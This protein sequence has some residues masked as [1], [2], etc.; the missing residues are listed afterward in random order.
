MSLILVATITAAVAASAG[1]LAARRRRPEPSPRGGSD[2]PE[3]PPPPDPFA[4]LPLRLGDVVQSGH[5]ERWLAGAVLAR[6]RGEVVAAV[7]LAPEGATQHAVAA[8]APPRHDVYWMDPAEVEAPGEPPATLEL[9]GVAME[10]RS[11][12]PVALETAGQGAPRLGAE[13]ILATY[14]GGAGSVALV[15]GSEGR[16]LAWAGRRLDPGDYDRLG[17]GGDD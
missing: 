10:R 6:E 11:R 14:D 3:A 13:G 15:L 17:S 2:P 4:S 9:R 1:Y 5:E 7:F 16:T 8:F 12:V